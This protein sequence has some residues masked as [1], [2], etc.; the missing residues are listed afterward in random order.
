[1]P[2]SPNERF[3]DKREDISLYKVFGCRAFVNI[4]KQRWRKNLEARATQGIFIGLDRSSYPGYTVYTPEFH[5]TYVSGNIVF[6]QNL[7]YDGTLEQDC[8]GKS[9]KGN[10]SIPVDNVDKYKYLIGT[11]H[12]D[13]DNGLLYKVIRVEENAYRGQGAYIVV[14]RAQVLSDGR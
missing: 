5:K 3:Y 9:V 8:A 2:K 6:H 1:M 10:D 12:I 4:P 14:Y 13:P 11:N 7:S